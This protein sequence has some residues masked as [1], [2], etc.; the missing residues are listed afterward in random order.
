MDEVI[1]LAVDTAGVSACGLKTVDKQMDRF[2][3]FE[4]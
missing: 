2:A 1:S 4:V 3:L